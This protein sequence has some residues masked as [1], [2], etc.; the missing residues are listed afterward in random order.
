MSAYAALQ[1]LKS[2]SNEPIN[3]TSGDVDEDNEVIGY[4][5]TLSDDNQNYSDYEDKASYDEDDQQENEDLTTSAKPVFASTRET[6]RQVYRSSFT[7]SKRNMKI[8]RDSITI[9]MDV[10][11]DILISGQC[12]IQ[13]QQGILLINDLH[14]IHASPKLYDIVAPTS[15]SLPFLSGTRS[16]DG[17]FQ[18]ENGTSSV[19]DEFDPLR[20]PTVIKISNLFTGLELIG[21]Y[22]SPFK[23]LFPLQSKAYDN[24][25]SQLFKDF[26]FDIVLDYSLSASSMLI[27]PSWKGELFSLTHKLDAK[28]LIY[29]I[30]GKKNSGK[31]TFSK[32]LLNC[33]SLN[34]GSCTYLDLD[35]GQSEFSNPYTLSI[36]DVH[37]P[38]FGINLPTSSN[39]PNDS[40]ISLYYGFSSPQ[41]QSEQYIRIVKKLFSIYENLQ[42]KSHLIVN[43]PGWIKGF[44][45]E[46][47]MEITELIHP[48]HL[49]YL[50]GTE[51]DEDDVNNTDLVDKLSYNHFSEL[52]GIYKTSKYSAAQLRMFN[53][54]CYFHQLKDLKYNF[55]T[56]ILDLPP[57]KLSYLTGSSFAGSVGV[58]AVTVLN[59]DVGF[60]LA[61]DDIPIMLEA[62]IVGFY[63][64]ENFD[65]FEPFLYS[66]S[67]TY[68]QILNSSA[69]CRFNDYGD[70]M[71]F[72]GLGM[73]HSI[74][75]Q[76]KFFN[77]YLPTN[78][79]NQ[80]KQGLSGSQKLLIVKGEGEI[81]S[82]EMLNPELISG[83]RTSGETQ[84]MPY[85]SF[86]DKAKVGGV[87]RGRRNIMRKNQQ[88]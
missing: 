52:P 55:H 54:L 78:N 68:P 4:E 38:F 86:V 48:D 36:T 11:D 46:L 56:H 75:V 85:V 8:E 69:Y 40:R 60:N 77:V 53:K 9:G 34:A 67:S 41:Q 22:H 63:L 87:W 43:T 14:S 82:C 39:K 64:I 45:K 26:S 62:S 2:S 42:N 25:S 27:L 47:L 6:P 32:L 79:Q 31:S 10:H 28:P 19:S 44:G 30:I 59:Y 20:F 88:R 24:S 57:L 3:G 74:N 72:M 71:R 73:V 13:V 80:I 37:D 81:P 1:A 61:P 5:Q 18:Q 15:Q 84:E 65:S 50:T 35:P 49:I 17:G 33:L 29:F 21:D 51:D 70:S 7:P 16:D 76:E 23:A 12:S 58:S 83:Y 66:R